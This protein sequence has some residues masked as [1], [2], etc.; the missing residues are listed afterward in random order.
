[1][2]PTNEP[3]SEFSPACIEELT[4][5]EGGAAAAPIEPIVVSVGWLRFFIW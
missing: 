1:M 4:Q 3:V 2:N 5:L